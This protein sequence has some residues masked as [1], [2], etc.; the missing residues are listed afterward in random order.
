MRDVVHQ[1]ELSTANQQKPTLGLSSSLGLKIG[2]E[3]GL[4][5]GL[6]LGLLV[7][8]GLGLKLGHLTYIIGCLMEEGE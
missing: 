1:Q 4:R 2:L 6:E 3:L 8:V 5:L 7:W